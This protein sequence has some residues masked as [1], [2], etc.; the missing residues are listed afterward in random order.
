MTSMQSAL[1]NLADRRW[2]AAAKCLDADP[3]A[4]FPEK[5]GSTRA[6]KRLCAACTVSEQCLEWAQANGERFGVWG[7]LSERER[8]RLLTLGAPSEPT[9]H[10]GGRCRVPGCVR[11]GWSRDLCRA[12]Q[13]R[14]TK[15][16]DVHADIPVQTDTRK[17]LDE[18]AGVTS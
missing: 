8:K 14:L 1:R 4:F 15:H 17:P 12:H 16:G 11:D 2:D 9:V 6:A 3:E 5:G 7:G 10:A 18:L 13:Q